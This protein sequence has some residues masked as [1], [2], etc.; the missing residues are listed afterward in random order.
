MG[1]ADDPLTVDQHLGGHPAQLEQRDFLT[2]AFQN[3]V[4]GIRESP[5]GDGVI[6][7][8]ALKALGAFRSHDEHVAVGG[9]EG[10]GGPA[11]LRQVVLAEGSGK[12]AVEDEQDDAAAV[13]GQT[14]GLAVHVGQLEIGS[15]LVQF[16]SGHKM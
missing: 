14:G 4:M 15:G 12:A 3:G 2:I 7:P 1:V 11:Q 6:R 9:L 13:V 5:E 10:L 8:V 16:N